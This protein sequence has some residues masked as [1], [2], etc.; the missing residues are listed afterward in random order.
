MGNERRRVA[1]SDL[2]FV[3]AQGMDGYLE[4]R[5][6]GTEK[7]TAA[8]RSANKPLAL[9]AASAI[10][11]TL[12]PSRRDRVEF[13]AKHGRDLAEQEVAQIP[14]R[15]RTGGPG[16]GARPYEFDAGSGV[17][18]LMTKVPGSDESLYFASPAGKV[19]L[20]AYDPD[21]CVSLMLTET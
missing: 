7:Q 15:R 13:L 14:P 11:N 5:G 21:F 3:F 8:S 17:Y 12:A 2:A 9:P 20:R 19:A 10:A 4:R 18:L 1:R 6:L 16:K